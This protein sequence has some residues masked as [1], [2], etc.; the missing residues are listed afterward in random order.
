MSPEQIRGRALD[1][2]SDVYSFGCT[3]Y[4]LLSGKLPFTGMNTNEVFNKHLHAV[5]PSPEVY[6]RNLTP[7]CSDL[8]RRTL[9]KKPEDRPDIG[10]FR[11]E[12]NAIPLFKT[13]P[14]P[15][16]EGRRGRREFCMTGRRASR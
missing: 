6:N 13:T 3:V 15:P 12:W 16:G 11:R 10:Q 4:Q 7:D 8:L 2:K 9:S 14:R 1:S 5:I